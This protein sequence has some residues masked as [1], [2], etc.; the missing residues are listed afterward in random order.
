MSDVD[1]VIP[2]FLAYHEIDEKD[3]NIVMTVRRA[4]NE[5][6]DLKSELEHLKTRLEKCEKALDKEVW[7]SKLGKFV[8]FRDMPEVAKVLNDE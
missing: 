7:N 2:S 4:V 8:K 5:Q 6:L 3:R 1:R